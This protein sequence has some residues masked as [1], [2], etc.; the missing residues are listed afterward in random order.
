MN[1]INNKKIIY[2]LEILTVLT[3]GIIIM[4]AKINAQYYNDGYITIHGYVNNPVQNNNQG[5]YYQTPI[6]VQPQALIPAPIIYSNNPNQT[7]TN[8]VTET[9]TTTNNSDTTDTTTTDNNS[10]NLASNAIFGSNS[11]LPSGLIQWIL[12]AIIILVIVILIRKISGAEDKYHSTPLKH[13]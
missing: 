10:S 9:N 6:Y 3:F 5:Y 13:A 12:L 8:S 1:K 2:S 7:S 11:F 4:P